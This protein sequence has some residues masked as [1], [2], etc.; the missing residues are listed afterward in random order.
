MRRRKFLKETGKGALSLGAAT[1]ATK[2]AIAM[3]KKITFAAVGDCIITRRVSV[4]RDPAFLG[5][6]EFLRAADCAFGNCEIVLI[7][8]KQGS[9]AAKGGDSNLVCDAWGADELAWMGIDTVGTANNHI[10]DYGEE[11]LYSTLSH[12]QRA[13]V[14]PAGSGEDLARAA[15]PA[16]LDT[17]G[18]RVAHVNCASTFP[19]YFAA[20]EA[21]PWVSGRPGLNP[22]HVD[23]IL[24][25][26]KPLFDRMREVN[27]RVLELMGA[28]AFL[29]L[30]EKAADGKAMF[31]EYPMRVGEPVDLISE[32]KPQ[33]LTR[34]TD[35]IKRARKNARLVIASIHAHEAR[36]NRE[37]PDPFIVQFAHAC[38]DAG[39]DVVIGTGPHL[40]RGIEIYQGKPIC[41]SLGNFFYQF[42]TIRQ[43]PAELLAGAGLNPHTLDLTEFH[44]NDPYNN[45]PIYWQTVAPFITF[46]EGKPVA[47]ILRPI[48]LGFEQEEYARGAPVLAQGEEAQAILKNMQRLSEPFGTQIQIRDGL[49]R[50]ALS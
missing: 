20:A 50:V 21:H 30:L 37:N 44:Q 43:L 34:I 7:D 38:I 32:I 22:L 28:Q 23:Y 45:D 36:E 31:G 48:S 42:R 8:G 11:G 17:P 26:E 47:F 10:L 24:Q 41:Y 9:P 25:I 27:N 1:L 16:Y 13:G 4:R 6:V 39:A 5:L 14:T 29:A 2:K 49:G 12:L 40:L 15:A 35:S 33:D 46:E 3:P 18:G 19:P